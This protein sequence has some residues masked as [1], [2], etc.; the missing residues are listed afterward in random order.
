MFSARLVRASSRNC[1]LAGRSVTAMLLTAYSR[2]FHA[3]HS[4]RYRDAIG[5]PDHIFFALK[6]AADV[7]VC[8]LFGGEGGGVRPACQ[9]IAAA[10]FHIQ[11]F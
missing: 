5:G 3:A 4:T 7:V 2:R 1:L 8:L 9:N 11:T 10:D 6:G